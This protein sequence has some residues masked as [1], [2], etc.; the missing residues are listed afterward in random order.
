MSNPYKDDYLNLW[1]TMVLNKQCTYEL[2]KIISD[3]KIYKAIESATTV[4]WYVVGIIHGLEGSFN[5]KKHLHNGDPLTDRTVN[6]PKGRPKTGNPPFTFE[7]SAI[8]ALNMKKSQFPKNWGYIEDVLYFLER[9][10]GLGY[11]NKG[12]N[13]PYLWSGSN[14]YIKGKYVSDG[15]YDPNAVSKQIG[16]AVILKNLYN[17]GE[18]GFLNYT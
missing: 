10:N 12:L 8:D 1:E 4:P 13:T 3:K 17:I 18:I 11:R 6:V 16:A 9:Y 5:F 7:E 2:D 14:H 15:R